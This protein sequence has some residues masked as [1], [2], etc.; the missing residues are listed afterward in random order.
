MKSLLADRVSI[1]KPSATLIISA[2]ANEMKANGIDVIN[3]S[4]G[5]PDFNTPS[6]SCNAAIEAIKQGKTKYTNVDGTPVLKKAVQDKFKNENGLDYE[7][8]EIVVSAGAKQVIFNAFMASLNNGDEV[9]IPAPYWVS[10]VEIVGIFG[11]RPVI[12]DAAFENNFKITAAELE[13]AIT[14]KTKWII[15]N[16]PSNPTGEV[17][18]ETELRDLS[19][20]LLKYPN[21]YILSDDIYEHLIF[22]KLMFKN[23]LNVEPSL[24]ERTLVVN[25]VSK[26]YSMTGWRIGYAAMKNKTFIKTLVNLQSQSTSNPSSISQEAALAALTKASYFPL[27]SKVKMEERRNLVYNGLTKIDGVKSLKPSGAFYIFFSV[28]DLLGKKTFDGKALS[29][30]LEFTEYLLLEAKVALVPGEAFGKNGFIRLSYAAHE[31]VLKQAIKRIGSA[32][33]KLL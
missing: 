19:K 26:S 30:S 10:Y 24:T 13:T 25:G 14:D 23:I 12:I 5:E 16:S 17:Y 18:T 28:E 8:N 22:D 2:K 20:V 31:D 33:E 7:L 27:D 11:G 3:L 15:L 29:S 9:I 6:E 1:L 4:L 32:I 21:I